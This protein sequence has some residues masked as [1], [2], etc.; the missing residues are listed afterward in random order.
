MKHKKNVNYLVCHCYGSIHAM[1][2]IK[3]LRDEE[4][5]GAV[6]GVVFL[7]LGT[8]CP[9]SPSSAPLMKVPAFILGK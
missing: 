2:L 4:L 5:H 8:N 9:A 7:A 6:K 1:R 3:K